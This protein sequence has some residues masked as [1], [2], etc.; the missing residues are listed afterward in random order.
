[1]K[2]LFNIILL[3]VLFV[4][5]Q[6]A[7]AQVLFRNKN[8]LDMIDMKDF[9]NRTDPYPFKYEGTPYLNEAFV[10]GDIF[11]NNKWH[12]EDVPLRYNIYDDKVEYK[13]P[14]KDLV[15]AIDPQYKIN[16]VVIDEDTFVVNQYKEKGWFVL[17]FFKQLATGK[18]DLFA[19]MNIQY[20]QPQPAKPF[21]DPEPA[22]FIRRD[23]D[24]YV[25]AEGKDLYEIKRTKKLIQYLGDYKKELSDFV[26]KENIS[27]RKEDELIR[28]FEY[29]NSL[30]SAEVQ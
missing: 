25:K 15:Y 4:F 9:R 5:S 23:N 18:A 10:D 19:K 12:I 29:Y 28:L 22:R 7:E 24:Y 20:K 3:L 1:M 17:G 11:Y 13:L 14:E 21:F 2:L 30:V 6:P 8:V 16:Q 27:V 26:R